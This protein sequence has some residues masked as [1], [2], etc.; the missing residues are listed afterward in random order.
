MQIRKISHLGLITGLLLLC[1]LVPVLARADGAYT[2]RCTPSYANPLTGKTEDG[3]SNIALGDS[4]VSS[5][6]ESQLLVEQTGG[7]L[8]LTIGLGLSSNVSNI[9]FKVMNSDGSMYNTGA[10]VTGKSSANGDTVNHYRIEISSLSQYISPV[11]FVTPMGRDVQFFIKLQEGT[12]IKGSGIYN[13]Q[14]IPAAPSLD[15]NNK[16]DTSDAKKDTSVNDKKTKTDKKA[17][18]EQ[19]SENE[20]NKNAVK[21]K[22]KEETNNKKKVE[23]LTKEIVFKGIRGLSTHD[24]KAAEKVQGN[25]ILY[26][27]IG[28]AVVAVLGVGGYVY[29]KKFKK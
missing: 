4:M 26:I 27:G 19:K 14:M 6:V 15:A 18:Q 1:S 17:Q 22:E 28:L 12:L 7:K 11:M 20:K 5:I 13:S 29:V 3:G 16:N 9:R 25:E 10:V 8:Y 24:V 23:P 2:I 21:S